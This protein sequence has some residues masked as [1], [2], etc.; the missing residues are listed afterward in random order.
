MRYY[1]Y[2]FALLAFCLVF[3]LFAGVSLFTPWTWKWSSANLYVK[4]Y[5]K[6]V[7]NK[8]AIQFFRSGGAHWSKSDFFS[9][10]S[11]QVSQGHGGGKDDQGKDFTVTYTLDRRI[12]GVSYRGVSVR[13]R[14]QQKFNTT[15]TSFDK[16]IFIPSHG[17]AN[18]D[19]SPDYYITGAIEN[20]A[21]DLRG[22]YVQP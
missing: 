7:N 1:I 11:W 13:V 19:A 6:D 5:N 22:T 14:Y 17:S 16:L 2:R 12:V 4:V 20:N 3:L 8:Y 9:G 18:V 15:E 10:N 21:S